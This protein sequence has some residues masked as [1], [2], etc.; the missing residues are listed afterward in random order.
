MFFTSARL[1]VATL[2]ACSLPG[3]SLGQAYEDTELS[4]ELAPLASDPGSGSVTLWKTFSSTH[5][6]K[7][8][9]RLE[10]LDGCQSSALLDDLSCTLVIAPTDDCSDLTSHRVIA[11]PVADS[12]GMS[13]AKKQ[14]VTTGFTMKELKG[15]TVV[16]VDSAGVPVACG[17]LSTACKLV[18]GM[19]FHSWAVGIA[20]IFACLAIVSIS[21]LMYR[22]SMQSEA[23][24]M[25]QLSRCTLRI[26]LMIPVY[27]AD[28]F[29]S[30]WAAVGP[31]T[32]EIFKMMREVYE[33]FVIFSFFQWCLICVGGMD[34]LALRQVEGHVKA[35][36]IGAESGE[37]EG[38]PHAKQPKG[39]HEHPLHLKQLF[40]FHYCFPPWSSPKQMMKWCA[41]GTLFYVFTSLLCTAVAF[42]ANLSLGP[43]SESTDSVFFIVGVMLMVAQTIAMTSLATF[44]HVFLEELKPLHPMGKFLSVKGV[45]FASFWQA[46]MLKC[47][48]H[49]GALDSLETNTSGTWNSRDQISNG[50]QNFLICI[51]MFIASIAFHCF[52][53]PSDYRIVYDDL[54]PAKQQGP[55]GVKKYAYMADMIGFSD[56]WH[57]A[58][59]TSPKVL[60]LVN[61]R[62]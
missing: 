50:V 13:R 32:G 54:R 47:L 30:L 29:I 62:I 20:G 36:P 51:E 60:H 45:V 11:Q 31:V 52:F 58:V 35:A 5:D 27:C 2:V 42:I 44:A 9:Y 25:P 26:M 59:Q 1:C 55:S 23:Y 22:H 18:A 16:L 39:K 61:P 24:L 56:I 43:D 14:K 48:D 17:V 38:A 34:T 21:I 33:A 4:A 7:L 12:N 41:R 15:K 3:A 28:A 53:Q 37:E 8:S 19:C 57:I 49:S 46:M 10:G 6:A 40:P